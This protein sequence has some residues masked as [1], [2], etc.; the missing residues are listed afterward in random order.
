[1]VPSQEI[2]YLGLALASGLA[3]SQSAW[4]HGALTLVRALKA[5][6]WLPWH[7][8]SLEGTHYL[9]SSLILQSLSTSLSPH[10]QSIRQGSKQALVDPAKGQQDSRPLAL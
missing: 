9:I 10:P 2:I 7:Q 3:S 5:A 1:M 6:Y 8:S 4:G